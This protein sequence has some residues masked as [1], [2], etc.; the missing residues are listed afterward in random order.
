MG[1]YP[2]FQNLYSRIDQPVLVAFT[3]GDVARD[4]EAKTDAVL[5]GEM[6]AVLRR[7]F[8]LNSPEPVGA[9]VTRWATDP[10]SFGSYSNIPLGAAPTDTEALAEP[11]SDRLFFAGEATNMQYLGT[12][13]GAFLSGR[14]EAKRIMALAATT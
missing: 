5:V 3:A 11:V 2:I 8:G 4:Q 1:E 14:R 12:V 13:H 7:M 9:L 6:M 10:F